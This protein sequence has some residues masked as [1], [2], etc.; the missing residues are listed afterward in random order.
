MSQDLFTCLKSF[1]T[2]A[3]TQNFASAARH[4]RISSPVLTKQIKWLEHHIGKQLFRRTTRNVTLTEAGE[5]YLIFAKKML[6]DEEEAKNAISNMETEPHGTIT[7]GLSTK[8][9]SDF[10]GKSISEFLERYPKI[11]CILISQ[12]SP[13]AVIEGKADIVI[14]TQ[15]T[16]DNQLVKEHLFTT[17]SGLFAHP[18]YIKKHGIPK[19]LQDL[20]NHNCLINLS[21]SPDRIWKFENDKNV[22]VTGNY[23]SPIGS[24][25]LVGALNGIGIAYLVQILAKKE[26]ENKELIEIVLEYK[27][28]PLSI[29]MYYRPASRCSI[30]R[31]L[32]DHIMRTVT[33]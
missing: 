28:A 15:K 5:L 13:S 14:S 9:N 11:K 21:V 33:F 32:A 8:L 25:T 10:I 4:L 3:D 17:P 30:V 7:I 6:A 20:K 23:E 22:K 12:N 18:S 16:R 19:S 27:T 24:D 1:V 31:L 29:Y 2:V 26:I